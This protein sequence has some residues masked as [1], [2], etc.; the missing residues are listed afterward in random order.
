VD[1]QVKFRT[2][3][4]LGH[5]QCDLSFASLSKHQEGLEGGLQGE[6]E[7]GLRGL[8]GKN[9]QMIKGHLVPHGGQAG[10]EW[11]QDQVWEFGPPLQALVLVLKTL[12]KQNGLDDP[13]QG[14]L[15]GYSLLNMVV[16]H[17][18]QEAHNSNSN[19]DNSNNNNSNSNNSNVRGDALDTVGRQAQVIPPSTQ[20]ICS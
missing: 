13:S 11:T 5:Q 15:G 8:E 7:R 14:G 6:M 12:L 4:D 1:R 10:V 9:L 16:A 2:G 17:M 3:E 18:R 19:N 20:G